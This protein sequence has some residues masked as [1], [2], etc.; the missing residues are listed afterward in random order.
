MCIRD[1]GDTIPDELGWEYCF[2]NDTEFDSLLFS[3]YN[4]DVN[5]SGEYSVIWATLFTSW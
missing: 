3:T 1:S 2:N 5:E 4:G